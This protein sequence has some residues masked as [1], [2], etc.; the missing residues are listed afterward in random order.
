MVRLARC[1]ALGLAGVGGLLA[2]AGAAIF[3]A[4]VVRVPALTLGLTI[5]IGL[6]IH[7]WPTGMNSVAAQ[8]S[9]Q[10]K[11]TRHAMQMR[12]QEVQRRFVAAAELLAKRKYEAAAAELDRLLAIAPKMPEAHVNMGFAMMGLKR[13]ALARDFF[14]VAIELRTT[15]MNA[16]FGVAIALEALDDF[17]CAQG[18][19]RTYVHRSPKG[20]PFVRRAHGAIWEWEEK[21][22]VARAAGNKE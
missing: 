12:D 21:V 19:M 11:L 6:L 13:Y 14:S 10:A 15:Q 1:A 4:N 2:V 3:V 7:Y 8:D 16:Y 17:P 22:A 18:A 9:Q 5:V 20:D